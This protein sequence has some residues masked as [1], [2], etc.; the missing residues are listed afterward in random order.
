MNGKKKKIKDYIDNFKGN[1]MEKIILIATCSMGIEA[2]LKREIQ[3]LNYN[4]LE[5]ENGRVVFEGDFLA[6]ARANIFLRTASK[7]FL[8]LKKFDSSNFDKLFDGVLSVDWAKYIAQDSK[9]IVNGKSIKSK[10]Q[11]V[12]ANQK[13]VKKAIITKMEKSYNT[14]YFP[15]MGF[16][17]RIDAIIEKDIAMLLLDLSGDGLHKR[18]YRSRAGE[19]PIKETLAAA[20]VDLSRVRRDSFVVDPFCGSGTILIEAATRAY[21]IAPGIKRTF[22]SED[23]DFIDSS[24]WQ[25]ARKEA[26]D[27]KRDCDAKFF[28]YDIDEK[29]LKVA[30]INAQRAGVGDYVHFHKR[31]VLDFTT[32][33]KDGIIISNPPY[34]ERLSEETKV[35]ELYKK[36]ATIFLSHSGWSVNIITSLEKFQETYGKW[37]NKNRKLYNGTIKSYFYQY[38]GKVNKKR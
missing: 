6:I 34:G 15:E 2:I 7:I 26:H 18:G 3:K 4:I 17:S 11:S 9:I 29:M 8:L 38:F 27:G 5:V 14:D 20:M 16:E 24:V 21:N 35:R 25:I 30:R 28:G 12:P 31:D 19:A 36:M 10:L 1:K 37:A 33:I 32:E 23:Y 13:M 22:I